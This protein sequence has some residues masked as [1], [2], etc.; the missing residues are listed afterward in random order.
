MILQLSLLL[1]SLVRAINVTDAYFTVTKYDGKQIYSFVV[2]FSGPI[3]YKNLESGQTFAASSL[4]NYTENGPS[5]SAL[6]TGGS[7]IEC[8]GDYGSQGL[9][10]P[11]LFH[12]G[13]F[14]RP[15]YYVGLPTAQP[16]ASFIAYASGAAKL[17]EDIWPN[18]W[19]ANFVGRPIDPRS[20][21]SFSF[22]PRSDLKVWVLV[23]S[24]GVQIRDMV[25]M[26]LRDSQCSFKGVE[27]LI[28]YASKVSGFAGM[29]SS[30]NEA[31]R[32]IKYNT[33]F[34]SLQTLNGCMKLLNGLINFVPKNITIKGQLRCIM[35]PSSIE[36]QKDACCNPSLAETQCCFAKT[37]TIPIMAVDSVNETAIIQSCKSPGKVSALL[38][39]YAAAIRTS[40]APPVELQER[41][42][43]LSTF[44]PECQSAIFETACSTDTDCAYTG[45][46][47]NN[48]KCAVDYNNIAEPMIKCYVERMPNSLRIQLKIKFNMTNLNLS[49]SEEAAILIPTILAIASDKDC[50][51]PTASIGSKRMENVY[52]E[53]G[54]YRQ[55]PIPGNETKCLADKWCSYNPWSFTKSQCLNHI[56]SVNDGGIC[57]LWFDK[58]LQQQSW[59]L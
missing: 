31:E 44:I 58:Y 56:T 17:N 33:I 46:C 12:S 25:T 1:F 38:L 30:V 18:R 4:S 3:F 27:Y 53:R 5:I 50:V 20:V 34:L 2:D 48:G 32:I 41:W 39:S 42:Q 14:P 35:P 8:S 16:A 6:G 59:K 7:P 49:P 51:G 43:Q 37:V 21:C 45:V 15:Q 22:I 13:I 28:N 9:S 54:N 26:K 29:I 23:D 47:G 55:N 19:T 57:N 11:A 24:D 52:D 40:D 10:I 36:W